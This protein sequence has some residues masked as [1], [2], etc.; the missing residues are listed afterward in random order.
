ME[1]IFSL[2]RDGEA[3]GQTTDIAV[4]ITVNSENRETSH[5][6]ET[7]QALY[8][9][10][11]LHTVCLPCYRGVCVWYCSYKWNNG[12]FEESAHALYSLLDVAID[13]NLVFVRVH[14]C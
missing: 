9:H 7:A 6:Q 4:N 11:S 12:R 1:S 2:G 8:G 14:L 13:I 10:Q 5:Q 3:A